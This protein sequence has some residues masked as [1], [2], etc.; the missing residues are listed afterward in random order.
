[1]SLRISDLK[2]IAAAVASIG[3]A[4]TLPNSGI[5]S[6]PY[7][8]FFTVKLET[9]KQ[10]YRASEPIDVRISITNVTARPYAIVARPPEDMLPL[11][12]RDRHGVQVSPMVSGHVG[13]IEVVHIESGSVPT[14]HLAP[15][16]TLTI[17]W[18]AIDKF[19]YALRQPGTY[20][21]T[22][23]LYGVGGSTTRDLESFGMSGEE[24]SNAVT[25]R[26]L[27]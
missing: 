24:K 23:S 21:I 12:V 6:V 17:G 18:M 27:P 22:T 26:I 16:A 1:M 5:R 2:Q 7:G 19:G 25:I 4:A 3:L 14:N 8:H 20:T 11:V 9:N 13:R 10:T 15:N